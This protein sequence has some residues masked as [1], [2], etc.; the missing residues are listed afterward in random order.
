MNI[1][2]EEANPFLLYSYLGLPLPSSPTQ[3]VLLGTATVGSPFLL[4]YSFSL[5]ALEFVHVR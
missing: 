5:C 3:L 4:S 2:M 1:I